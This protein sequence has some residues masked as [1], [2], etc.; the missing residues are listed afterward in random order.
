MP[1]EI[2]H[3]KIA[4]YYRM[5]DATVMPSLKE[6]ISIS[7]LESLATGTPVI[8][9]NVG[10]IKELITHGKNGFLLPPKNPREI[11][12]A[13]NKVANYREDAYKELCYNAR[14]SIVENYDW[15]KIADET[16]SAYEEVL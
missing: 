3:E 14:E 9:T 10:G 7:G 16:I 6:A 15:S 4:K 12:K 11:A 13:I 2:E 5:A 1:G 8:G